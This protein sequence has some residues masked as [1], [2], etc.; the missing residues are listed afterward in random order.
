MKTFWNH[1]LEYRENYNLFLEELY[2]DDRPW[3]TDQEPP[4]DG[5]Q[6]YMM[7]GYDRFGCEICDV[8]C[9]VDY[10]E[11]SF[12]SPDAGYPDCLEGEWDTDFGNC[13]QILGWKVVE[14]KQ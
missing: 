12:Y 6:F 13:E 4:K 14:V 8:G 3:I 5:T 10:S 7:C 9:W 11:S 2:K 1:D